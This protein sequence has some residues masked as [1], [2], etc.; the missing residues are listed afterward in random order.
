[1]IINKNDDLYIVRIYKNKMKDVDIFD[2]DDI[3]TMFKDVLV[4]LKTKY[5]VRGFCLI[6]V[7]VNEYFGMIVEVDN[8][9]KYGRDIDVKIKF[10]IDS[11]FMFEINDYDIDKYDDCYLYKNKYYSTYKNINDSVLIYRDAYRIIKEGIKIK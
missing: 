11:L 6:E 2:I 5:N 7:F 9:D 3:S 1:M 10:H 8:I 4:K